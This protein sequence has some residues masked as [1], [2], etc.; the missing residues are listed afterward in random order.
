MDSTMGFTIF[1][2]HLGIFFSKH[3]KQ[4]QDNEGLVQSFVP[5]Q[6][7]DFQ[8][9][10]PLIFPGGLPVVA[11][12]ICFRSLP[13]NLGK[14]VPFWRNKTRVFQHWQP[15]TIS[16]MDKENADVGRKKK[17]MNLRTLT[18][19]FQG[20]LLVTHWSFSKDHSVFLTRKIGVLLC[21]KGNYCWKV[22]PFL[23][24]IPCL[25]EEGHIFPSVF[26]CQIFVRPL[27]PLAIGGFFNLPHWKF[28]LYQGT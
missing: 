4:T 9:V 17:P 26:S 2:H 24:W 27:P 3:L 20:F 12:K 23:H 14:V 11:S 18:P 28:D 19:V 15:E 25:R 16:Q 8:V 7:G 1:H 21:L 10:Q 5:L 13:Q 22:T 6:M